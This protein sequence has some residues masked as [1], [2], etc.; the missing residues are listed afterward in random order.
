MK[1]T[2][3]TILITGGSAGIGFE[4][5]KLLSE[6][7]NQVIIV[8]R[9]QTR[10]DEAKAKLGQVTAIKA[11][12]SKAEEVTELVTTLKADFPEL[13]IVINN[14][15]RALLYN[16]A[17]ENEDAFANAADE[18]L[19]N[20]LSIIRLNQQ[21][22][23]LLKKQATAAIVNVSS[24]VAYVPGITLPTYAA[25]KAAVHSYT[26]SLRLSLENTSV[27]VFELMPP[28]VD[29]EFSAGIG[30]HNGIKPAVVAQELLTA[31][32]NNDFEIRVGDT[33]K[34]YELFL[35]SPTDALNVM[36]AK[37]AEWIESTSE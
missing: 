36:N 13:N 17:D 6:Q 12:V 7:G 15:G 28:L 35:S 4:T 9:D 31:L 2:N 1:T 23:P 24:I 8:G 22:L 10:L 33:A 25:S 26:T 30:G 16:L 37:R 34:M 21:L 11:D 20:Y 19:T 29:T 27:K 5:A 32:E 18:M 14:A 3:N